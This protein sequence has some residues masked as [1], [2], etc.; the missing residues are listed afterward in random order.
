MQKPT[1]KIFYLDGIRG[2]AAFMVVIHHFL[3]AFYP[4]YYTL[5]KQASHINNLDVQF[6]MSLFSVLA[7]GDFCVCIFFVLSGYVLSRKYFLTNQLDV[8]I[9]GAQRRF[10]RL[11]IPVATALLLAAML[12][13]LHLIYNTPVSLISHS[14]WWFMEQWR[15]PHLWQR[16]CQCLV[17]KTMFYGDNSFVTSMW[18]ISIEL[19][20][21]LFVFAFLALT[22]NTYNRIFMLI[23]CMLYFIHDRYMIAFALGISLNYIEVYKDIIAGPARYIA[24]AL[25]LIAGL[26]LGSYPTNEDIGRAIQFTVFRRLPQVIVSGFNYTWYHTAGAYLLILAFVFSPRLQHFVSL[27]LFRFLGYISFSIYLL[28]PLV[29]GSVSSYAFLGLYGTLGYNQAALCAFLITIS[30]SIGAAWLMSKYIDDKG[31]KLAHYIYRRFAK[32]IPAEPELFS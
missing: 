11:Y 19:Y 20:G 25:L 24:P 1:N 18:T 23:M 8:L 30:V 15:I 27:R 32:K 28:H 5:D 12:M 2:V 10:V 26:I 22:H 29:L 9:S 6:G 16:L 31:I 4:S 7:N 3:L 14:E 17:Y 21:S 13:Q